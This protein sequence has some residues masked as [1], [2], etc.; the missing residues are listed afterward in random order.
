MEAIGAAAA[1][2]GMHV[3]DSHA[4]PDHNR[5]VLSLAATS[6]EGLL[7]AI[8]EAVH[9]IDL[10]AHAGVHPR[11]GA[12]DVVPI[13]PLDGTSIE[14]CT[15]LAHA[16]GRRIWSELGVPVYFYGPAA[17]RPEAARLAAIRAGG[18]DP[19][20]G[21]PLLHPSAGAV[22]VG[23][24]LPLVAYNVLL[25][26]ASR[27][28]A[29]DFA[30]GVRESSGGLR[31][32]QALAFALASGTAQL[33]MNLVD[34]ET[35]PPQRV[36]EGVRL[37]AAQAGLELGPEEVVGLCPARFATP[38]AAGRLLEGRLAAAGGKAGA[39]AC[40]ALGGAERELVASR[41][42]GE[43]LEL[44]GLTVDAEAILAGA[45]RS[46]ALVKVLR[47]AGVYAPE[48]E[49]MLAA[50]ARGWRAAVAEPTWPE[51]VA[52]LDRWL[53]ELITAG[54]PP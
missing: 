24:R 45:E 46:V 32:V 44:A 42:D 8:A 29:L 50:A 37:L 39:T 22:C 9:R 35:A 47:A 30:R 7:A 19:D 17:L 15:S 14:A 5:F 6:P 27:E 41:L 4:D 18:L 31:G 43:A 11:V 26:G 20:L 48:A 36:L 34:L 53:A 49:R 52:A 21:G 54:H 12:A 16:L 38:A 51:R 25:P 23:A 3:L 28:E 40:R 13:V 33:S 10:R 2:R 1:A